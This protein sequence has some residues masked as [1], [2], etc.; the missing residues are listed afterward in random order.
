MSMVGQ[1]VPGVEAA[2]D[3]NSRLGKWW[4]GAQSE[5][6]LDPV[7]S[8]PPRLASDRVAGGLANDAVTRWLYISPHTVNTHLRHVH[9]SIE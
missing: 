9:R 7:A 1:L 6:L 3:E 8:H 2:S 5:A 4:L